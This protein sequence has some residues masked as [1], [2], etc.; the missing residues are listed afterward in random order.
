MTAMGP[1]RLLL[2]DLLTARG[3]SGEAK[4]WRDSFSNSWSI[5]DVLYLAR[6]GRLDRRP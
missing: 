6:L 4:R 5:A 3:D 2:S 1:E